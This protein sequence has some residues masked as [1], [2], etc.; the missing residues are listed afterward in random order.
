MG[1]VFGS[2]HYLKI[3]VGGPSL[4]PV[5]H[6]ARAVGPVANE[7]EGDFAALRKYAPLNHSAVAFGHAPLFELAP[8]S[9]LACMAESEQNYAGSRH[10]EAVYHPGIG[11][12]LSDAVE[13]V[14][15]RAKT[16]D[17]QEVSGF[18]DGQN[19]LVLVKYFKH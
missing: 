7:G 5:H 11:P 10:I 9:D 3:G 19:I 18:G 14:V 12:I 4:V 16:R 8:Q 2:L 1:H 13:Q 15:V 6:L 17:T